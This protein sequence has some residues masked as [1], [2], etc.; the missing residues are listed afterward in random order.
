MCS[1]FISSV[2][3]PMSAVSVLHTKLH[4][5]TDLGEELFDICIWTELPGYKWCT[6]LMEISIPTLLSAPISVP[7]WSPEESHIPTSLQTLGITSFANFCQS[8]G[9]ITSHCF[10]GHSKKLLMDL[11]ISS[12]L[13][14]AGFLDCLLCKFPGH[15]LWP[16]FSWDSCFPFRF[17]Q[18]S[19]YIW[20]LI[21]LDNENFFQSFIFSDLHLWHFSL[22]KIFTFNIIICV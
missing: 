15:I 4:I 7:T 17:S 22:S 5:S 14:L 3:S 13:T 19:L 1:L 21:V 10:N 2:V 16:V 8:G 6:S 12:S 18:H 11:N 9:I 20:T